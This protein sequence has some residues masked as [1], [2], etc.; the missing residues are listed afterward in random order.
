MLTVVSICPGV[1]S[2]NFVALIR[3]DRESILKE[4]WGGSAGDDDNTDD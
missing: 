3:V 2:G 4:D 1:T